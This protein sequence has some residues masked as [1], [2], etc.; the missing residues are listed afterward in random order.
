MK[1]LNELTTSGQR[2]LD[3]FLF[4]STT[5]NLKKH[6]NSENKICIHSGSL[7][8]LIAE[9]VSMSLTGKGSVTLFNRAFSSLLGPGR[10]L[11][12]SSC[13]Y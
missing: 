9:D 2:D 4:S 5:D 10:L 13:N 1:T 7:I 6:I 3:F 11:R 8:T 12:P